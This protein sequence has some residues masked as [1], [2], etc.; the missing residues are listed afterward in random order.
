MKIKEEENSLFKNSKLILGISIF[1]FIVLSIYAY[2]AFYKKYQIKKEISTLDARIDNMLNKK[3]ELKDFK[4]ILTNNEYI[5]REARIKLNLKKNGENVVV[6]V[7]RPYDDNSRSFQ[8][9]NI[10][11]EP[12]VSS[13]ENVRK[14]VEVIFGR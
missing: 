13:G 12:K 10:S 2:N 11:K 3:E 9:I 8:E 14:W 5:E 7:D 4:N 1:I 6:L